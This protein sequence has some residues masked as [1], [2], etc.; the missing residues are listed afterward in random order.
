[1]WENDW[2][3]RLDLCLGPGQ[4]WPQ[5]WFWGGSW[6]C[7][8]SLCG[9]LR[10]CCLR[11]FQSV[12]EMS[13]FQIKWRLRVIEKIVFC[14]SKSPYNNKWKSATAQ[15]VIKVDWLKSWESLINWNDLNYLCLTIFANSQLLNFSASQFSLK[16]LGSHWGLE[17]WVMINWWLSIRENQARL[18]EWSI[19]FIY[20]QDT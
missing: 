13:I 6:R 16:L 19:L 4:M 20:C 18:P 2:M 7:P 3:Y 15:I 9:L 12:S 8:S 1:M 11:T 5:G 17:F 14:F 10:W